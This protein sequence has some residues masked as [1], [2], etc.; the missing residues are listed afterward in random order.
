[1]HFLSKEQIL[2][3]SR[4]RFRDIDVPELGGKL[5]VRTLS[6]A[7]STKAEELQERLKAGEKVQLQMLGHLLVSAIVHPETNERLFSDEDATLLLESLDMQSVASLI[8][9]IEAAFSPE[10][11]PA[12][13]S[14]ASPSAGLPSGSA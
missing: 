6:A 10:E 11:K 5:R 3:A 4:T 9:K 12:G 1:M 14:E 13:N 8:P 2:A 7:A